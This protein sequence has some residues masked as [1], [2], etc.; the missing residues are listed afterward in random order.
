MPL[1]LILCVGCLLWALP[2]KP[3]LGGAKEEKVRVLIQTDKGDLEVE[4]EPARAPLTTANFLKYV[5][6]RHYDGGR[7]HRIVT[8][9][10]QP[11]NKVKIEVIQAAVCPAKEKADFP[12]IKLETTSLTKLRHRDGTISMARDGPDT[13]T[14]EFFICVGDQPALDF[15]GRRNPDGQGFAAFGRV[16]N[17]MD[18]VRAIQAAPAEG[19]Q[20]TPPIKILRVM[21]QPRPPAER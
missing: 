11:D 5:D 14:S 9:R 21:R 16:V 1:R 10:N 12:P 18:V 8:P 20:L 6:G 19:Q 13:A 3:V 7:F 15:G 4:L 2:G 17:G